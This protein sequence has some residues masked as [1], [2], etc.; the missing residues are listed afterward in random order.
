MSGKME[1]LKKDPKLSNIIYWHKSHRDAKFN[2]NF[3][4]SDNYNNFVLMYQVVG[5]LLRNS[6]SGLFEP[7]LASSWEINSDG[8]FVKFN[9]KRGIK[10][11]M[12]VEITP[13]EY[14][15]SLHR[16]FKILGRKGSLLQ[17]DGLKGIRKFLDKES[18][19][20][21]GI[22]FDKDSISF[23][24]DGPTDDLLLNF[25]E[26]YWGF[27]SNHNF[28][29][30]G[31]WKS[32]A[33]LDSSGAYY[34]DSISDDLRTVL[35]KK[36]S[37]YVS[38]DGP[39][40]IRYR[41]FSDASEV[42]WSDGNNVVYG[43]LEIDLEHIPKDY[44]LV[45]SDPNM[46]GALVLSPYIEPFND[47]GLRQKVL[48]AAQKV[49]NTRNLKSI[50]SQKSLNFNFLDSG[51]LL[52][53]IIQTNSVKLQ[54]FDKIKVAFYNL[55]PSEI[56]YVTEI[57]ELLKSETGLEYEFVE[58]NRGS[59]G[60][61]DRLINNK[62]YNARF[63]TVVTGGSI[64]NQNNKMMFCSKLGVS[65]PDPSE[66][67]CKLVAEYESKGGAIDSEYIHRFYKIL[68]ADAVVI[69]VFHASFSWLVAENID[70][71]GLKSGF[72]MPRL[73]L[74]QEKE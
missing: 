8:S 16:I 2:L 12:G 5:T 15:Q 73:D 61:T 7:Y 36:N 23:Q 72:G 33:M 37:S 30:S 54:V 64:S 19:N 48:Q 42:T 57:F 29:S 50:R 20:I 13:S 14:Y 9:F 40:F 25:T 1:K 67:I 46:L 45:K 39:E 71:F 60:E 65:F 51:E 24:F 17:F 58:S 56:E 59:P 35:V 49:L 62:H 52:S 43:A 22:S 70:A 41:Y 31:D 38:N 53:N 68:Y 55:A 66:Q 26:P 27:Y 32:D 10:T 44:Y 63:V 74:L 47:V 4:N 34:L 3:E 21:S 18:E 6:S 28:N 69:P 11:Q